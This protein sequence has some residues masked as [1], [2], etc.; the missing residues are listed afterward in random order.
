MISFPWWGSV[1]LAI[2]A[3]CGLK[4]GTP[5][6]IAPD[7][8]LSGLI[9]LFAPLCAMGL[10]LLAGKQLYDNDGGQKNSPPEGSDSLET[11]KDE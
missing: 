2:G 5:Y 10:L 9:P 7:S 11:D 8:P 3:Y 4:Y 1:F 6:I